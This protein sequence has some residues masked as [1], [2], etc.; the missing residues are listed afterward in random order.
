MSKQIDPAIRHELGITYGEPAS[1]VLSCIHVQG[2]RTDDRRNKRYHRTIELGLHFEEPENRESCGRP[3][4]QDVPGHDLMS[5]LIEHGKRIAQR[6]G[7]PHDDAPYELPGEATCELRQGTNSR[8]NTGWRGVSCHLRWRINVPRPSLIPSTDVSLATM[9]AGRGLEGLWD[10]LRPLVEQA[11]VQRAAEERQTQL[12]R[13]V[14]GVLEQYVQEIAEQAKPACRFEQRYAA[15][16][17]EYEA[18]KQVRGRKAAER[19]RDKGLTYSDTGT[20][21]EPVVVEALARALEDGKCLKS[22]GTPGRWRFPDPPVRDV[23]TELPQL[24]EGE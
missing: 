9:S 8:C 20:A 5:V 24:G 10:E 15:L 12:L 7:T 14:N 6:V 11:F 2:K 16:L 17:A 23:V 19:L 4:Y 21:A 13:E 3:W 1:V 18:E 22:R